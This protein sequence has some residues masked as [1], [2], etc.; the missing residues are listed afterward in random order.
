MGGILQD[1]SNCGALVLPLGYSVDAFSLKK[2]GNSIY[3]RLGWLPS[4]KLSEGPLHQG[5]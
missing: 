1:A 3:I 2:I 4:Q 5:F